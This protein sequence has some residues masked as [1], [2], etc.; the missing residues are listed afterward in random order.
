MVVM[1][2]YQVNLAYSV[3]NHVHYVTCK[4]LGL[5]AGFLYERLKNQGLLQ[6]FVPQRN[7]RRLRR[8]F[9][10]D[11]DNQPLKKKQKRERLHSKRGASSVF[12]KEHVIMET[13]VFHRS[14]M[15]YAS[16][17]SEKIHPKC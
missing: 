11:E 1:C 2:K 9:C 17:T 14:K 8:S 7:R 10:A 4:L 16:S 12:A 3:T 13:D 15:F 6:R 5:P